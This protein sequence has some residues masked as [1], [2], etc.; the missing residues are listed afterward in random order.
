MFSKFET[1]ICFGNFAFRLFRDI[2]KMLGPEFLLT[3]TLLQMFPEVFQEA[4]WQQV[5]LIF[6]IL[7]CS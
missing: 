1:F 6:S 3:A 5:G 2:A 4:L 7:Y